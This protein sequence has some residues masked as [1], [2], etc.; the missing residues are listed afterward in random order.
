MIGVAVSE[1][2][3]ELQQRQGVRLERGLRNFH[4]QECYGVLALSQHHPQIPARAF[5]HLNMDMIGR[6]GFPLVLRP[7]LAVSNGF[8]G[9][10]LRLILER[11][12][13]WVPACRYELE[14]SFQINCTILAEPALGGISTSLLEQ[15]NPEWH[16]SHD[17]E[18]A[19]VLDLEVL[20]YTT[21]V[22]AAWAYILTTAGDLEAEW[23]LAEYRRAIQ[24]DLDGR[25]I[26]DTQIYLELKQQEMAS[27]AVLVSPAR[28]AA[29]HQEICQYI[30]ATRAGIVEGNEIVPQGTEPEVAA[31]KRLY[32]R[33]VLGGP[34]VA[35]CFTEEQLQDVG[36]PKWSSAQLVLKSWADGTRSIYDITRLAIF[37]T[38]I[39]LELGYTL[40]FFEH[41][42]RQGIV[43]W[44]S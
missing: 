14:N 44:Q 31:S 9:F 33:T 42:A 35:A 1:I 7:G 29:F 3:H 4:S 19:Q 30:A 25:E 32:P 43:T 20:R 26:A 23:I 28:K 39:P 36:S 6:S 16:T 18:G 13:Q 15:S 27:I 40:T 22:A 37:E 8:S 34:A 11:A 21:L 2:L 10:L 41:Y 38:G 5:A 17:R 24:S 12:R